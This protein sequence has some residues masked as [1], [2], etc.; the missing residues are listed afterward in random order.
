[1]NYYK[2]HQLEDTKK[3]QMT[4]SNDD[5]IWPIGYCREKGCQHETAEEASDC[6]RDY[7]INEKNGM[8][9]GFKMKANDE[10]GTVINISSSY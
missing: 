5:R 1:M 8:M 7:C 10:R 6:Y 4:C 3:W 2:P 9:A